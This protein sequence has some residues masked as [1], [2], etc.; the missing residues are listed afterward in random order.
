MYNCRCASPHTAV[1]E[2]IGN[3]V[4]ADAQGKQITHFANSDLEL[5][6]AGCKDYCTRQPE[7]TA[8]FHKLKFC[9]VL[10]PD[11]ERPEAGGWNKA[12]GTGVYPIANVGKAANGAKCYRKL[13]AGIRV[14]VLQSARVIRNSARRVFVFVLSNA[15]VS[16]RYYHLCLCTLTRMTFAGVPSGPVCSCHDDCSTASDHTLILRVVFAPTRA[17]SVR[18]CSVR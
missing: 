17:A 15:R 2:Y 10:G 8:F 18:R 13:P 7:C 4:C 14:D 1:Y 11:L 5:S 6:E 9:F 16:I 3:A 12:I